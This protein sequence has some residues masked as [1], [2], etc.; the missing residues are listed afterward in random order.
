MLRKAQHERKI[1][2]VFNASS[3]RPELVEG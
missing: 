2:N 1:V 3:V